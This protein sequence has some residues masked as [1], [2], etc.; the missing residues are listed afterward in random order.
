LTA[1]RKWSL[2]VGCSQSELTGCINGKHLMSRDTLY[3]VVW[4]RISFTS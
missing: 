3:G 4:Y 2:C 1:K